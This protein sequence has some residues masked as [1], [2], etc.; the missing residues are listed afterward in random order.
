MMTPPRLSKQARER[1]KQALRDAAA[2][3]LQFDPSGFAPRSASE[4]L[5]AYILDVFDARAEEYWELVPHEQ[6]E[7]FCTD[8][9]IPDVAYKGIEKLRY[10]S[11]SQN[12]KVQE[13]EEMRAELVEYVTSYMP[14]TLDQ[15][16]ANNPDLALPQE[17]QPSPETEDRVPGLREQRQ[18]AGP[19]VLRQQTESL[20]ASSASQRVEAVVSVGTTMKPYINRLLEL[21]DAVKDFE[22]CSPY[23]Q[24]EA[25][26]GCLYGFKAV[27][28]RFVGAARRIDD[29][30]IQAEL[31]SVHLN[32]ECIEEAYDLRADLVPIIDLLRYKASDPSW[33]DQAS[34]SKAF[35][36]SASD[37]R[38]KVDDYIQEVLENTGKRITKK[39]FWTKAGYK[40]ATQFERWQRND[41]KASKAAEGNFARV[42][43]EKPHLKHA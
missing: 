35:V 1:V 21:A 25:L 18:V 28:K 39:D 33:G 41:S 19:H 24:S 5:G 13:E 7:E 40:D 31:A 34:T 43:R 36:D 16:A 17:H 20:S 11:C 15:L 30:E 29:A 4:A 38:A 26:T 23:D 27:A 10:K 6:F 3:Y 37:P 12:W 14:V 22:F 42:L 32:P 8:W 2:S 9:L